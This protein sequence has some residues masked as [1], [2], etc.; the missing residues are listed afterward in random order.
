MDDG[1]RLLDFGFSD[2][3]SEGVKEGALKAVSNPDVCRFVV[4]F[5][6]QDGQN[7]KVFNATMND[8]KRR[9]TLIEC[10]KSW[11]KCKIKDVRV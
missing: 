5:K 6:S 11:W 9:V 1:Y 3:F 7:L 10:L 4:N 8:Y 2:D